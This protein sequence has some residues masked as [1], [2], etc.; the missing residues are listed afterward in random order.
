MEEN[1]KKLITSLLYSHAEY[2]RDSDINELINY[3]NERNS[4][5]TYLPSLYSPTIVFIVSLFLG[6]LGIDRM[7]IGDIGWGIGKLLITLILG[8]LI[9][10]PLIV[11]IVDLCFIIGNVKD[12]NY[13]KVLSML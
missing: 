2:F 8:W 5:I 7:M 6:S 4:D 1:N 3:S 12:K 13:N 10:P 11:W 9:I